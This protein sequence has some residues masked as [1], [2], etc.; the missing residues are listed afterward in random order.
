MINQFMTSLPYQIKAVCFH[1]LNNQFSNYVYNLSED[2]RENKEKEN[3]YKIDLAKNTCNDYNNNNDNNNNDDNNNDDDKLNNGNDKFRNNSMRIGKPL[4]SDN[5]INE[6]IEK[7]NK[8]GNVIFQIVKTSVP[9]IYDLYFINDE[10]QLEKYNDH[11]LIKTMETSLRLRSLFETVD[12]TENVYIKCVYAP[13]SKKWKWRPL[14]KVSGIKKP[15]NNKKIQKVI[16][17]SLQ[18][19]QSPIE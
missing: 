15:D 3:G 9:D 19:L 6:K 7:F 14:E 16:T 18:S 13:H 2:E 1:T 5:K 12:K 8:N 17:T 4:K 10:N 11:P